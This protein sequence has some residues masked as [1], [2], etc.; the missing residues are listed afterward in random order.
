M[1][2]EQTKTWH[3]GVGFV[4]APALLR[5]RVL[6]DYRHGR[7]E[8]RLPYSPARAD[9]R[10]SQESHRAEDMDRLPNSGGRVLLDTSVGG[11]NARQQAVVLSSS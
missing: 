11:R 3:S 1:D 2:S 6:E 7:N 4:L 10:K 5:G 8:K 9:M